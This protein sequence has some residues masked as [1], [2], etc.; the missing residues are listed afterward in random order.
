DYFTRTDPEYW[1]GSFLMIWINPNIVVTREIR[2]FD[3]ETGTVTFDDL[4]EYAIYPDGRDQAYAVYNSLHELDYAGEYAVGPASGGVRRVYLWPRESSDPDTRISR[5]IRNYGFDIN[6]K[7]HIRIRGFEVR[8]HSGDDLRQGVAIGTVTSSHLSNRGI[9]ISD[10][11]ITH[12]AYASRGGYGGIY[13]AAVSGVTIR[14]NRVELNHRHGGIFLSEAT[15]CTVE[16]NW[17]IRPGGTGLRLY[18]VSDSTVIGNRIEESKACHANGITLYMGCRDILVA[19]NTVL[20]SPSP[21]TFQDSGN[22]YFVNNIIDGNN[23]D[24]NVNEWSDTSHGPWERGTIA[25]FHNVMARNDRNAALNIGRVTGENRY[26]V[27][28]NIIDGGAAE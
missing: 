23:S 20:D 22:L 5:S 11:V 10:N 25:F 9:T 24:S 6:D 14:N 19:S 17:I 12:N 27:K 21:L 26:I 16:N 18:T 2:S 3:P 28:H 15:D 4:G 7:N 13:L 1:Q 8:K